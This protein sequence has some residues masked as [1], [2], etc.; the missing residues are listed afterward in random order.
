MTYRI[1]HLELFIRETVPARF[2]FALGKAGR[3][4]SVPPTTSPLCHVRMVI[5]DDAGGET[6]G[7]AGD[8]LSVRW[9][10]KRPGRETGL[11]R[12][13]LASLL[14]FAAAAYKKGGPFTS[15]FDFWLA[16]H[17]EIMAEGARR[18]QEE[19]TLTFAS[20][21]MER[22]LLDGVSRLAG[23]PLWS[24]VREDRLG[25]QPEAVH[26]E[27]AG[28]RAETFLPP[29][30]VTRIN[31]RHT[32]GPYDPLTAEDWPA[33]Q[34][35]DDGLP[36]TVEEYVRLDGVSHFKV[37]ITGD[38]AFDLARLARISDLLP[39]QREPVVTLDAN[40]AYD[41]LDKLAQFVRRL[42]AE[43]LGLFQ[44]IAY[45]EQPLSR[46]LSLDKS[47]GPALRRIGKLKPLIIDESDSSLSAFR[48]ARLLGYAGT[49]HKN[50][51]GV[52]KSLMSKALISHFADQGEEL[53]L[54]GED[55]QNLPVAPLQQDFVSVG[56]LG[57]TH[58]ERNGHHYNFGLSMLSEKDKASATRRHRDLYTRRGD[59]WFLNVRD[60]AVE[61][62]S[63][64]CPGFGVFDEPDWASMEPLARWIARRHPAS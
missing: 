16:R 6:F 63:L 60:G 64:Q 27:L 29:S 49:S 23:R 39:Y 50:C 34:R 17:R 30:P 12:R 25:F 40:E 37:K 46:R 19:L 31:I 3:A 20:A 58:C 14:E 2:A 62:G 55:L 24:M 18:E 9:L 54:S 52:F 56:M 48:R 11:K 43:Q 61:C 28:M 4:E 22:A 15:P 57:L 5:R 53:L 7:C 10:D 21:I 35:L 59:E 1:E 36:E 26:K 8:R 13:E 44:H 47:A 42:E 33:E 41:D 51:K 32:I 38:A 45:I